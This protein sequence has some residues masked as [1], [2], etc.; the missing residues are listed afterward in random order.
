[1][2]GLPN[3]SFK[4]E[5]GIR[6]G[7]TLS[8]YVF[9]LCANVLSSLIHKGA[10]NKE[11]HGIQV[12]R[13]APKITHLFFAD[14]SLLFARANQKKAEVILNILQSYQ[15]ASGQLVSLEKSEASKILTK[16]F[17]GNNV[18]DSFKIQSRFLQKFL[19]AGI[20]R[21]QTSWRQMWDI[22]LAMF[23]G[24]CVIQER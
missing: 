5:R 12:A 11:I 14:D 9:I 1:V 16:L 3:R 24:V 10:R 19:R 15:N 23:G 7:D 4:P 6:Q 13:N 20:F 8:P 21:D 18:G 17:S 22:N 2:N